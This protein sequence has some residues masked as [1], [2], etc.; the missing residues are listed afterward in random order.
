MSTISPDIQNGGEKKG[1]GFK[2]ALMTGLLLATLYFAKGVFDQPPPQADLVGFSTVEPGGLNDLP[3]A[4]QGDVGQ[5]ID[6]PTIPPPSYG[7]EAVEIILPPGLEDLN[8]GIPDATDQGLEL[9]ANVVTSELLTVTGKTPLDIIVEERPIDLGDAREI[10][11]APDGNQYVLYRS[12]SRLEIYADPLSPDDPIAGKNFHL[13]AALSD[14]YDG[15][16]AVTFNLKTVDPKTGMRH[17]GLQAYEFVIA[18]IR[19]FEQVSGSR[20]NVL[21]QFSSMYIDENTPSRGYRMIE[22]ITGMP[23]TEAYMAGKITEEVMLQIPG[24]RWLQDAGYT[25]AASSL[26][27]YPYSSGK[28][29]VV[30]TNKFKPLDR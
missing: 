26:N 14:K 29:M 2:T 12:A 25:Y 28:T 16:P 27:Y 17:T 1:S 23:V 7:T 8:I 18:S 13:I 4:S 11:V 21:L 9:P 19:Y 15:T 30:I 20:P 6:L 3:L 10:I 5:M 22:E 24:G